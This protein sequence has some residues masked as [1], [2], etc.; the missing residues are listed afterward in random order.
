M[1]ATVVSTNLD[2]FEFHVFKA[3]DF[4]GP[5]AI[6]KSILQQGW[7]LVA[8]YEVMVPMTEYD[9]PSNG[10]V[11][12]SRNVLRPE[13]RFLCSRGERGDLVEGLERQLEAQVKKLSDA[14][15]E[16]QRLMARIDD[17]ERQAQ[18]SGYERTRLSDDLDTTLE[19]AEKAEARLKAARDHHRQLEVDFGKV[20]A[21]LGEISLKKILS[22]VEG[23]ISLKKILDPKVPT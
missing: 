14:A 15:A 2:G 11:G 18:T 10:G 7:R 22:P 8:I 13:A 4:E 1:S 5:L 19:R 20:R 6:S 23:E 16:R 17:L 3:Q 21:A 9:I 12:T